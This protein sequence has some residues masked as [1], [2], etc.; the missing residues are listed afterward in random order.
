MYKFNLNQ[1]AIIDIDNDND[2]NDSL[3]ITG[4]IS[5]TSTDRYKEYVT[6]EA[7]QSLCQQ[8]DNTNLHYNHDPDRIIGRN[9]DAEIINNQ[10]HIKSEILP[11]YADDIREKLEFGIN[12]GYS[13]GGISDAKSD[14]GGI[15]EFDLLEISL[16]DEP[17]NPNTYATVQITDNKTATSNCIGGLCY[18]INKEMKNMANQDAQQQNINETDEE[19]MD[20]KQYPTIDDVNNALNNMKQ[21]VVEQVRD[22]FKSEIKQ[23]VVD[24]LSTKDTTAESTTNN[25]SNNFESE[26]ESESEE[27]EES[28]DI[29]AQNKNFSDK[30]I[31]NIE[32]VVNEKFESFENKFF[33][34]MDNDRDP[35][36][37]A[38]F[39]NT[40][41]SEKAKPVST[42]KSVNE[43][44]E[45][46]AGV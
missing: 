43:I 4:V 44:A 24:I 8:V 14:D 25:N 42:K 23:I 41:K 16:T 34:R 19:S 37:H 35:K 30:V 28:E 18:L 29:K 12:Y 13:I 46:L 45:Y 5:D 32:N 9:Y 15:V 40:V 10:L 22:E 2:D 17:A 39:K 1:K 36:S 11:R 3:I 26:S 38:T 20:S 7:L 27:S 33:S 31:K 6:P 21:D